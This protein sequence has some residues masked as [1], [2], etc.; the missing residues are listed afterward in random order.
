MKKNYYGNIEDIV[1][2]IKIV[3]ALGTY[4][5]ESNWPRISNGPDL[6]H[7]IMGS[8]GMFGVTS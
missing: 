7:I 8:E 4:E 5:K 6:F 3:T 2:N 1:Q